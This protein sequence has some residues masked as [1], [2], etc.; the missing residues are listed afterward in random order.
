MN[1]FLK[2]RIRGEVVDIVSTV[3]EAAFLALDI[4]KERASDDDAFQPAIDDYSGGRQ[5]TVPPR[6]LLLAASWNPYA[7]SSTMRSP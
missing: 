5:C 6:E 1:D 7:R 4:T 3:G 2:A